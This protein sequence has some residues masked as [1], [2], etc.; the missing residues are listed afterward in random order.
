MTIA[1]SSPPG[2]AGTAVLFNLLDRIGRGA[3]LIDG[4]AGFV[5][6]N[7]RAEQFLSDELEVRLRD[8]RLELVNGAAQRALLA[9]LAELRGS[10]NGESAPVQFDLLPPASGARPIHAEM[11]TV[12]RTG[13][14]LLMLTD[15]N[16]TLITSVNHLAKVFNLTEREALIA[17]LMASPLSETD[18]AASLG[19]SLNTLRT[20]R[21]NIYA[22]IGVANRVELTILHLR[23]V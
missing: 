3:I 17:R 18:I 8:N 21:K 20:H 7:G 23:L 11:V 1:D 22:K 14:V 2:P 15:L 12:E 13:F 10:L 6:A 4:N 5:S 9:G 16:E 19:I